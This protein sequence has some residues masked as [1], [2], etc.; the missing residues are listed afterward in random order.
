MPSNTRGLRRRRVL[1]GGAAAGGVMMLPGRAPA[2]GGKRPLDGVTLNVSC[3]SAAYP[4]YL[5]AYIPEFEQAT[6]AKVNYETPSF[7]IYNQRMDLELSTGSSAYDVVNITFIFIGRWIGAGWVTPLDEF[8]NDPKRTPADWDA[9]DLLAG[10]ANAFKDKAGRVYGIPWI[11]DVYMAGASRYDLI[12][13]TGHEMPGDFT[14]LEAMLKAVNDKNG[15]PGFLCENHYGWTWIAYLQGFGGNVFR[16]PPDDLMPVLDSAESIEAADYFGRLL[17]NYGPDGALSYVYD[18]VLATLK[19]GRANYSTNNEM[20]LV[21]LAGR[22]SKVASTCAFSTMPGGP[23]GR[24]PQLATH[25][26]GIPV[27]SKNKDA[28]WQFIQWSMSKQMVGRMFSER[29]YSSVTRRSVIDSPAFKQKLMLNG[30]DVAKI[31]LDSIERAGSGYMAYRTVPV[32]PQVDREIDAAIQA[33][34][35]QEKSAKQAMQTA[36]ANSIEQIKRS[37]V[38]L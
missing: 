18:Q 8:I 5:A 13:Q 22:D 2:Q 14:Q 31:Y 26:W 15:I 34:V 10:V 35:S 9:G 11:A 23:A 7:P 29:G 12:K 32:Y 3:W 38:K 4:K 20:F 16:H 30:Y 37:G 17:R 6:G 21:Q 24:F 1:G 27:G 19:Q 33:I 36:Q 25:G 28:A